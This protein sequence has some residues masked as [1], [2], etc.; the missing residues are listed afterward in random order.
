MFPSTRID[1]PMYAEALALIDLDFRAD[2]PRPMQEHARIVGALGEVA[3]TEW[4][5]SE[6]A[7]LTWVHAASH[8]LEGYAAGKVEIKS[9]RSKHAPNHNLTLSVPAY[10]HDTQPVDWYLFTLVGY[11]DDTLPD[12][13]EYHT[14]WILGGLHASRLQHME[15]VR[16]GDPMPQGGTFAFDSWQIN[17]ADLTTPLE[18]LRLWEP[19]PG[20]VA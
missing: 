20:D 16:A 10:N 17:L 15:L 13:L 2:A 14:V 8:D 6:H 19:Y 9:K 7:P 3:A 11:W 5:R 12:V 18:L 4:L 1:G